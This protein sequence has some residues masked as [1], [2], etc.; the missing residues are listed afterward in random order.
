MPKVTV[1]GVRISEIP[2][3]NIFEYKAEEY[4]VE[5][6]LFHFNTEFLESV[7]GLYNQVGVPVEI[8]YHLNFLIEGKPIPHA[9][10]YNNKLVLF[11]TSRKDC[12]KMVMDLYRKLGKTIEDKKLVKMSIDAKDWKMLYTVNKAEILALGK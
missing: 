12:N 11:Y 7:M 9:R 8:E 1:K 3:Y 5:L 6:I 4:G 10:Y 2:E